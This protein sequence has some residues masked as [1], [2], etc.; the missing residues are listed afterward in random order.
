MAYAKKELFSVPFLAMDQR[1]ELSSSFPP[2]K[3]S[4]SNISLEYLGESNKN[5]LIKTVNKYEDYETK[6][7]EDIKQFVY[8][9]QVGELFEV[10]IM[11]CQNGKVKMTGIRTRRKS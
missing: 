9:D 11:R 6:E 5:D 2:E 3:I 7:A 4:Y 8:T 10:C 1:I